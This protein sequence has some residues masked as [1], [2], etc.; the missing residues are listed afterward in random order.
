MFFIWCFALSVTPW[1]NTPEYSNDF[2]ILIISFIFALEINR[3]NIFPALTATF[4]L[5]SISGLFVT[6][7]VKLL[8]NPITLCL[9]KGISTFVIAFFPKLANQEPKDP[10]DW[11]I[12]EFQLC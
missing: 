2:M 6:L 9:A 8:T 4:P 3:V 7:E 1:N 10:P 12:L 5:I 11:I